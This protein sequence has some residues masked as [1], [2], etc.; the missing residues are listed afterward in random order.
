MQL[1]CLYSLLI[2]NYFF[3][4]FMPHAKTI[5]NCLDSVDIGDLK[6]CTVACKT[7]LDVQMKRFKDNLI[8]Q[9]EDMHELHV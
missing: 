8:C 9:V 7:C 6:S 2:L 1:Q 4:L 3:V 5:L